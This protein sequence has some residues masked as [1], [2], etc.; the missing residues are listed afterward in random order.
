MEDSPKK[1]FHVAKDEQS[2]GP[3]ADDELR[4][5]L[6]AGEF[7][8]DDLCWTK[9][10]TDWEPI[11]TFDEF[12][13]LSSGPPPVPKKRE[14]NDQPKPKSEHRAVEILKFIF[15]LNELDWRP[16]ACIN[17]IAVGILTFA[18]LVFFSG[19]PRL[20]NTLSN[21]GLSILVIGFIAWM[22]LLYRIWKF[23]PEENRSFIT[24]RMAVGIMIIPVVNFVW[25][26]FLYL[27]LLS[28]LKK[29]GINVEGKLSSV[30]KNYAGSCL[31]VIFLGQ[32]APILTMVLWILWGVLYVLAHRELVKT[33]I[34]HS[35]TEEPS[36]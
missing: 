7:S 13:D 12:A 20:A 9:G 17:G 4:N 18:F 23:L 36:A 35:N 32:V 10:M 5:K 3:L 2:V 31:A 28:G 30:V 33:I 24:P 26:V 25:V 22:I 27:R 8:A 1:Q 14:D 16:S 15:G 21:V 6:K 19:E 11:R 29:T 34:E